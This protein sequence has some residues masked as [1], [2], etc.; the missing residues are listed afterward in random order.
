MGGYKEMKKI[1]ITLTIIILILLG[2]NSI[3]YWRVKFLEQELD[4]ESTEKDYWMDKYFN[5]SSLYYQTSSELFWCEREYSNCNYT[6]DT[7]TDF[8]N[9]DHCSCYVPEF[10]QIAR[11]V[12]NSHEYIKDVYDCTEFTDDYYEWATE[13]GWDV[14]K[15]IG[16]WNG[17]PHE[18]SITCIPI[19][20]TLGKIIP[21]ETYKEKYDI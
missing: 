12:A 1:Y 10:L 2:I 21:P 4:F 16:E 15:V 6:V 3:Q 5:T 18:W 17:N 11:D 7:L 13:E 20:N 14:K 8:I 19:E 9:R